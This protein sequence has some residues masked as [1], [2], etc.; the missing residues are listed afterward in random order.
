MDR[1]ICDKLKKKTE[2]L[3]E[4]LESLINAYEDETG[5]SITA[6]RIGLDD[7]CRKTVRMRT[8]F[9]NYEGALVNTPCDWGGK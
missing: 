9:Y 2:R 6:L 1:E 4:A 5:V 7:D 8:E 3:I